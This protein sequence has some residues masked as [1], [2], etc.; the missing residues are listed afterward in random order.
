[1]GCIGLFTVFLSEGQTVRECS[2]KESNSLERKLLI[3]CLRCQYLQLWEGHTKVYEWQGAGLYTLAL[4]FTS[5]HL[6]KLSIVLSHDEK[7]ERRPRHCSFT[8]NRNSCILGTFMRHGVSSE[9]QG[10]SLVASFLPSFS[11]PSRCLLTERFITTLKVLLH[12]STTTTTT[13]KC[14]LR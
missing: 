4:I 14:H 5:R 9:L 13:T 3:P 8:L 7:K 11:N 12:F 6:L 2:V 10:T 1:M